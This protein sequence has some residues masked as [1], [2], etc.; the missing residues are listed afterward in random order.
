MLWGNICEKR[1][2][3]LIVQARTVLQACDSE[4]SWSVI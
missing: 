3:G 4:E 1:N 2:V